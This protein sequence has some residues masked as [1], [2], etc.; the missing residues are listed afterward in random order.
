MIFDDDDV[1]DSGNSSRNQ[2]CCVEL[3]ALKDSCR[4]MGGFGTVVRL[5]FVLGE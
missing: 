5:G 1:R 3:K 2:H 4:V